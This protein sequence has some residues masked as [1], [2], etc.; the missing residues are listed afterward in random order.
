MGISTSEQHESIGMKRIAA[1]VAAAG[2]LLAGCGSDDEKPAAQE[3]AQGGV[4]YSIPC[5]L[6]DG[7]KLTLTDYHEGWAH[8]E[9]VDC[10]TGGGADV[11]IEGDPR[12]RPDRS[13][14]RAR[15]TDPDGR[16]RSKTFNSVTAAGV[17]LS[18]QPTDIVRQDRQ[19]PELKSRTIGE[20]AEAYLARNE[21]KDST[22][23]LYE[24]V[25]TNHLEK[26]RGSIKVGNATPTKVRAWHTTAGQIAQAHGPRSG[27][28][29]APRHLQRSQLP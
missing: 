29:P 20:Y 14:I 26:E 16:W 3:A 27:V 24:S 7:L 21:I 13:A 19:A 4:T 23:A 1:T 22:C 9:G 8:P 6:P 5:E 25:W 15:F 10:L 2:L 18:G 11:K 28:P 12:R 17:W